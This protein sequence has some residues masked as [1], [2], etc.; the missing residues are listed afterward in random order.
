MLHSFHVIICKHTVQCPTTLFQL[1]LLFTTV[2]MRLC[3]NI[4]DCKVGELTISY[5]PQG[6][7]PLT[8]TNHI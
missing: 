3:S 2:I 6:F 1:A 7:F 8:F 5:P 4:D